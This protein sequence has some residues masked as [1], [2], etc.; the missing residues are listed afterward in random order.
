MV[1]THM[2]G[3]APDNKILVRTLD[4]G[5]AA[6]QLILALRS[7]SMALVGD[8]Y[9]TVLSKV[10]RV[11]QEY[12]S[13]PNRARAET[14]IDLHARDLPWSVWSEEVT[15]RTPFG[16]TDYDWA[17]DAMQEATMFGGVDT[18]RVLARNVQD[19]RTVLESLLGQC[20]RPRECPGGKLGAEKFLYHPGSVADIVHAAAALCHLHGRCPEDTD[21]RKRYTKFLDVSFDEGFIRGNYGTVRQVGLDLIEAGDTLGDNT[22]EVYFRLVLDH[23][24][25]LEAMKMA[26]MLT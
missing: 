22:Q 8:N 3:T 10:L 14:L 18:V 4:D 9:G 7:T 19:V 15:K 23:V 17:F 6:Q 24:D 13:E 12:V 21:L 26:K 20:E 11:T 1:M 16:H 2:P 5:A 25:P